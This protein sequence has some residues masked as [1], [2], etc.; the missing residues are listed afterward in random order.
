MAPMANEPLTFWDAGEVE[1]IAERL[2][3]FFHPHLEEG[4]RIRYLFRSKHAKRNLCEV[5]GAASCLTGR[6]AFLAGADFLIEIAHDIWEVLEEAQRIALIDHELC[7]CAWDEVDGAPSIRG[8]DLEEF[9]EIVERH[10]MWRESLKRFTVVAA[11]K[12][13]AELREDG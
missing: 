6:M 4:S 10:G 3:P 9:E 5:W 2:I 8:H 11:K 1:E 13:A 7:H 12:L